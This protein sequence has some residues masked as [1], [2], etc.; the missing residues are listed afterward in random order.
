MFYR[1][2]I[3]NRTA[4]NLLPTRQLVA[5]PFRSYDR[6]EQQRSSWGYQYFAFRITIPITANHRNE[7]EKYVIFVVTDGRRKDVETVK[8]MQWTGRR[9]NCDRIKKKRRKK[10]SIDIDSRW[11]SFCGVESLTNGTKPGAGET[12]RNTERG[13]I[14]LIRIIAIRRDRRVSINLRKSLR[15]NRERKCGLGSWYSP[16]PSR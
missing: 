12:R 10:K 1:S 8:R 16:L 7:P 5:S 14:Y 11:A 13:R 4:N 6:I 2:I 15:G 3:I 9:K